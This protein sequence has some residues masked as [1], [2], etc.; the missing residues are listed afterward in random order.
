M[1]TVNPL[2][3]TRRW[4]FRECGVGLGAIALADL[5]R[6]SGQAASAQVDPLA[7]KQPQS[8][9]RPACRRRRTRKAAKPM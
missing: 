9:F 6:E 4:F 3:V 1:N 8:A 2:H 5:L 7:P